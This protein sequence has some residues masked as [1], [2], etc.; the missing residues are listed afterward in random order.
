MIKPIFKDYGLEFIDLV[1][2]E[3]TD[4][5]VIHHTGDEVDDDLSA[6]Q[7]HQIHLDRGWSGIGYHFVI[8]KNGE[9]EIGRPLDCIGSHAYGENAHTVG[10]HVCGNFEIAEP[11]SEQIESLAVLLNYL[12]DKFSLANTSRFIVGHLNLMATACPGTNLYKQLPVVLGKAE[13]YRNN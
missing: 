6:E 13:F 2:R 11:T 4:M 3:E 7:I 10:I 12:T 5:I 8:R 9:M 1:P